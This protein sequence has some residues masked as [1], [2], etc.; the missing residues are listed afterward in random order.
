MGLGIFINQIVEYYTFIFKDKV[1]DMI[2]EEENNTAESGA[3]DKEGEPTDKEGQES[4]AGDKK[5][6]PTDKEGPATVEA[7]S[8]EENKELAV[9]MKEKEKLAIEK[10][11]INEEWEKI[12]HEKKK[13]MEEKDW[14]AREKEK[15][16]KLNQAVQVKSRSKSLNLT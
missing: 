14:L 15:L 3:G 4:G 9:I 5:G 1:P 13:I 8:N 6:A 11:K 10:Q 7:Y 16:A 2:D 12:E